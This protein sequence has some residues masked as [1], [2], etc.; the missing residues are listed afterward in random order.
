[1]TDISDEQHQDEQYLF[2]V[3]GYLVVENVLSNEEVARLNERIDAQQLAP[4]T[5]RK[6]RFGSA[7][8]GAGFLEWGQEFCDLLDHDRILPLIRMR[9]GD[10]FRLDRIYGMYQHKTDW[11]GALHADYGAT[12]PF[13]GSETGRFFAHRDNQVLNGFC[14]VAWNLADAGPDYGGFAC[15]PGS[16]KANFKLPRSISGDPYNSPHVVVP[17][18]PAG[19]AVLFTEAMTHGTSR[20][21]GPHERRTL[22]YKY[23]LSHMVWHPKRMSP[24]QNFQL[25]E[26]QKILFHDPTDAYRFFPSLFRSESVDETQKRSDLQQ[27]LA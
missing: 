10:C 19:S 3:R 7:P 26:R 8:G 5:R 12:A 18:V 4:P 14:V 16:H 27:S 6:H 22:L 24:P 25:T 23:C 9:L 17:S 13:S 11:H 21:H 20:W 1:M 2:D 15:V